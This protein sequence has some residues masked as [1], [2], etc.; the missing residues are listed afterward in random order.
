[1]PMASTKNALSA[2]T[3]LGL[4]DQLVQQ[5]Q[6]QEDQRKKTQNQSLNAAAGSVQGL[7]MLPGNG[8]LMAARQLGLVG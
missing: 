1:M 7:G 8:T 4:G 6:D 3:D 5:L 2:V